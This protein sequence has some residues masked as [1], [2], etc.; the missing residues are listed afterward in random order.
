[1]IPKRSLVKRQDAISTALWK[2]FPAALAKNKRQDA[3]S[4]LKNGQAEQSS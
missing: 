1:M 4:S 2:R 3:I